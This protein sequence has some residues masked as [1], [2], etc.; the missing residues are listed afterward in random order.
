[1]SVLAAKAAHANASDQD[2]ASTQVAGHA[3]A[4]LIPKTDILYALSRGT[5]NNDITILQSR[6]NALYADKMLLG[7]P[8]EELKLLENWNDIR[9]DVISSNG[10]FSKLRILAMEGTSPS[11]STMFTPDKILN[12]ERAS[13]SLTEKDITDA[14]SPSVCLFIKKLDADHSSHKNHCFYSEFVEIMSDIEH[15][16]FDNKHLQHLGAAS[17]HWI[18][19]KTSNTEPVELAG[20]SPANLYERNYALTPL[21]VADNIRAKLL[22]EASKESHSN[23]LPMNEHPPVIPTENVRMLHKSLSHLQALENVL[24]YNDDNHTGDDSTIVTSIF[25]MASLVFNDSSFEVLELIAPRLRSLGVRAL[26]NTNRPPITNLLRGPEN[27]DIGQFTS[28]I[29]EVPRG[30]HISFDFT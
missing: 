21:W 7:L 26:V 18:I 13:V 27:N 11:D 10:M 19:C 29:L 14:L 5:E 4:L 9:E 2:K 24:A 25:S 12:R 28:M 17:C 15:P 3:V 1:M 30:V 6:L 22:S 23:T 20:A 16:L 8:T